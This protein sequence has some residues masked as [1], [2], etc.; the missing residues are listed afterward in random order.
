MPFIASL[1][2]Y[3]WPEIRA[4]T[5]AWW[6]GLARHLKAE[7]FLDVPATLDRE[8]AREVQWRSPLLLLSQTCGYPL[9]HALQGQ[10]E[11]VAAP[12]YAAEGCEEGQ[13][14]SAIVVHAAKGPERPE[15]L[16]GATAAFNGDDSLSGHLALKAVFAPLARDGRF[17]GR[18]VESGSHVRSMDMVAA[19]EADV[20]AIDCVSL[21]LAKAHRPKVAE[22]LRAIAW[23]PLAPALPYVTAAGRP[24][25]EMTRLKRALTAAATDP[26]LSAPR[27]TLLLRRLD[28]VPTSAYGRVLEIEAA[29]DALGY[30]ELA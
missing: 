12:T 8:A 9:T 6:A 22:K 11:V 13:Y 10:V 16:R 23:S 15:A 14:R 27:D 5:D 18:T 4:A 29:A 3:D 1:P 24:M 7:G 2:M 21:A 25:P 26:A 20:A 19:G 28:F 17:F 30:T